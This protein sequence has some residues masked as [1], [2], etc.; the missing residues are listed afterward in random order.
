MKC[1]E[2]RWKVK[3]HLWVNLPYHLSIQSGA[4]CTLFFFFGNH[5]MVTLLLLV[6][7]VSS[8]T[9]TPFQCD[10]RHFYGNH[11]IIF[12]CKSS[13]LVFFFCFFFLPGCLTELWCQNILWQQSFNISY[14]RS[15]SL[16]WNAGF[17]LIA[18]LLKA[19][20]YYPLYKLFIE[21]LYENPSDANFHFL[22]TCPAGLSAWVWS[23]VHC[24]ASVAI[25]EAPALYYSKL[26]IEST[27]Q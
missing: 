21:R 8:D 26:K 12:H 4:E 3:R 13:F 15:L 17:P 16:C 27:N 20:F 2:T 10:Q 5:N 23:Q 1:A 22:R 14:S 25:I 9:S 19:T 18:L 7:Y 11:W 24:N 6:M